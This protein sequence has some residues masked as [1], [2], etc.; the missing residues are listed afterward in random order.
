MTLLAV[1]VLLGVLIFV[2]ELGHFWAAKSVGVAVQRF[3][4]GLGPR[5]WGFHRGD[6]EYVLSAIPLGGYVKMQGMEDEVL[7]HLEGGAARGGKKPGRGDFDAQPV[8][9]RAVVISAGVIMNMIFAFFLYTLVAAAW[10]LQETA[11]TRVMDVNEGTLPAGAEALADIVPGASIVSIGAVRPNSWNEIQ[12]AFEESAPGPLTVVTESPQGVFDLIVPA[13]EDD[14][15]ALAGSL[16]YWSDP[17]VGSVQPGTPAAGAAIEQGDRVTNV[18]GVPVG[19]WAEMTRELGARPGERV[20]IGLLRGDA[21]LT[22]MVVLDDVEGER[23]GERRGM[24]G[25]LQEPPPLRT[26]SLGFGEAVSFGAARTTE[27]TAAIL[28]FLRNL[29]TLNESPRSVGSIGTIWVFSG[30]AAAGGLSTFLGFMAFFS[31]N[32]AIL[33]MLPIPPLDGGHMVFL[34]IEFV[35][36][37]KLGVKQRVRWGQIGFYVIVGIMVWALGNDLLRF[38]GL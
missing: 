26:V 28:R 11:V 8:W 25:I 22:R 33:N 19:S 35:R 36:G 2:H 14:R 27:V 5:V 17:V 15:R 4:I 30:A 24:L 10:G 16:Q 32:L 3:S 29:V 38:F 23:A 37:E 21:N 12:R 20:E 7:E 34:G 6:T 18:A 1:V 31:I 13:D 9:A